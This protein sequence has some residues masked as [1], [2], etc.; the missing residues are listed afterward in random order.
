MDLSLCELTAAIG[1][2][3]LTPTQAVVAALAR[4][5]RLNPRLNAFVVICAESALAAAAAQTERLASGEEVGPLAGVP[6][7]VKDLCA[8]ARP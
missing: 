2:R 7:G 5:E 8:R 1:T 6:L 3:A 4:I